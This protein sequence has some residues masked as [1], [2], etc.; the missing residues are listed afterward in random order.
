M[1]QN[2][3]V[4]LNECLAVCTSLRFRVVIYKEAKAILAK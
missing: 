3:L 4:V 1:I 2:S